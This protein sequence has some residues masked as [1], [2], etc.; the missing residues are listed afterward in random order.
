[1]RILALEPYYGGSHRAFLD[2]WIAHSRHDWTLFS[3]RPSKWKWRMRHSAVTLADQTAAAAAGGE[4]WDVLFCSDMLNLAEYLGLAPAWIRGLPSVAYFHENQ[5]TYPY[6]HQGERDL[7]FGITNMT[8]AL[9]AREVW[10]NSAYHRDDFLGALGD[11]LRRLPDY[12]PLDVPDR[13]HGK[14]RV[15]PPGI[16][17]D[18]EPGPRRPGP[19]RLLWAARWEHDKNPEAFFAALAGLKVR[20]VPFRVSVVGEQFSDAPAVFREAAE[21]FK[22]EIDHW[23]FQPTRADYLSVLRDADIFVSTAVHEFFGISA[24]EAMA[25]GCFPV[26]PRRLAYPELLAAVDAEFRAQCFYD[27]DGD[28]LVQ[29]LVELAKRATRGALWQAAPDFSVCCAADHAWCRRA[30]IMD[31]ALERVDKSG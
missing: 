26:L 8:T 30:P 16:D 28:E 19:A 6:R 10:F 22:D 21:A 1:M 24:V 18:F 13:I 29:R 14:A 7:H 11:V 2:G 23:G 9:A 15:F 5:L 4:G 12:Q 20:G 17:L 27:D 31:D 3:L 25:S